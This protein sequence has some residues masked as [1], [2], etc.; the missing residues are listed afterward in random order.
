[1][2]WGLALFI[3]TGSLN[4][5]CEHVLVTQPHLSLSQL[6]LFLCDVILHKQICT[7]LPLVR[8]VVFVPQDHCVSAQEVGTA[9]THMHTFHFNH[10][11]VREQCTDRFRKTSLQLFIMISRTLTS[12]YLS[13]N[14]QRSN[15]CIWNWFF[16]SNCILMDCQWFLDDVS[17]LLRKSWKVLRT[18]KPALRIFTVSSIP[19]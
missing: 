12:H 18:G 13:K 7:F 8:R 10:F 16:A 19:E 17:H 1:M 9:W 4:Y 15:M 14:C 6:P 2:H 5:V 11:T 3:Y